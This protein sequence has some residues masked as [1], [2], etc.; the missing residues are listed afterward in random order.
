M[1]EL[2]KEKQQRIKILQDKLQGYTPKDMRH[3]LLDFF[4]Q[5]KEAAKEI[6]KDALAYQSLESVLFSV[7]SGYNKI[8][9]K[10][11]KDLEII[12]AGVEPKKGV[13]P[14]VNFNNHRS[15]KYK[16]T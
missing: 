13:A 7:Q 14:V 2:I 9:D 15:K 10:A 1:G 12:L 4:T 8:T 3:I 5:K 6:F 16:N 11:L